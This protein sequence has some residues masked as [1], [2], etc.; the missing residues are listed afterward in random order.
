MKRWLTTFSPRYLRSLVYML[1]STEY[2]LADFWRWY[3]RVTDFRRVESRRRLELT[4]KAKLML[5]GLWVFAVGLGRCLAIL[6]WT[7]DLSRLA[8]AA[9]LVLTGPTLIAA[10]AI[11]LALILR[12][13]QIP[14]EGRALRSARRALANHRGLKIAIAGSY[15]KTSMRNILQTV[16]AAGKTVAAPPDSH[17][18][19]L[20]VSRFVATLRGD[21]DVII[22]EL[23]EYYPGDVRR[24]CDVIRPDLGVITGVNEAHLEKFVTVAATTATIFELAECLGDRPLYINADDDRV[25]SAAPQRC[26]A[27]SRAGCGDWRTVQAQ[28]NLDGCT[29]SIAADGM[30]LQLRTHLLGL[31][32]LGP[33]LAAAHIGHRLGLSWS[34]LER[35]LAATQPVP[36]RMMPSVDAHGVTTIDDSYNGNPDGVTVLIDFLRTLSTHRRFYVTPGLV[37]MGAQTVAIHRHI[38]Q[39]LAAAR[40]ETAVLIRN[41]VTP[42]IAEGLAAAGYAGQVKWYPTMLTALAALPH[43]TV[44]G[45][46]VVLQNDW[47]DQYQ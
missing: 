14:I 37:E 34:D 17:N 36:H 44:A 28:T 40:I 5:A 18:T 33:L 20:G 35:G 26:I 39:Q 32:Q 2:R 4:L 38:G 9:M 23:G 11:G 24:L 19:P 29:A 12:A 22:F 45:D 41:S 10:W 42:F 8:V 3:M 46:V 31:H 25:R 7:L 27:Y 21:E 6:I 30:T 16:L 13:V 1:Q 43:M 47:P 15:G